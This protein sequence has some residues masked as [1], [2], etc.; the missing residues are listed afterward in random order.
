MFDRTNYI[1][2]FF[3]NRKIISN[4]CQDIDW[5]NIN[6]KIPKEKDKYRLSECLNCGAKIP[7]LIENIKRQPPK[8]CSFCSNIGHRSKNPSHTNQWTNTPNGYAIGNI[9]YKNQIITCYIDS[10]DYF[11]VSSMIWRIS[12]KKQK[13]YLVSGSKSKNNIVYL[14]SFILNQNIPKG[15]E[16]DH[17]DGNS[18]NNRKSNLR[19]VTRI[20]NIQ[21]VS[22]RID[23]QIGVRGIVKTSKNRYQVDFTHNN[24]RYHFKN[25]KTLSEAIYC[26]KYAEEYFDLHMLDRNPIA[27]QYL[28]LS[29]DESQKIKTYVTTNITKVTV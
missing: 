6:K 12:K 28:N 11:R 1:G 18:L 8:K 5:I 4:E 23:N 25:W 10:E 15:Y 16:I 27:T 29:Q 9:L 17:I 19:I 7:V 14:H 26:R 21:N 13:Y 24:Q 22:A 2:Q 20:Q 3:G